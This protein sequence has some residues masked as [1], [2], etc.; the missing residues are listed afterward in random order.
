MSGGYAYVA[1]HR[2]GVR[3]LDISTPSTPVEIGSLDMYWRA[4]DIAIAGNYA[5]VAAGSS[6]G[7]RVIDVSSPAAPFE[8]GF[9]VPQ[10]PTQGV[11]VS[12]GYAYL[13]SGWAGLQIKLTSPIP[14]T[15]RKQEA[16]ALWTMPTMS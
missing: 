15:R 10:G 5:Y 14:R 6:A 16:Q 8:V 3:I 11:A 7:I 1:A 12:N 13:A 9:Y 4:N 2:A